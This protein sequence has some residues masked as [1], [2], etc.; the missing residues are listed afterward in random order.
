M[1]ILLWILFLVV[2]GYTVIHTISTLRVALT[3]KGRRKGMTLFM[4]L[5]L[6]FWALLVLVT[7]AL[8]TLVR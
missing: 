1:D 7:Y 5:R 3:Y 8:W 4:V 2:A 6:F